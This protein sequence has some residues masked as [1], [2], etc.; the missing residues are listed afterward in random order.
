TGTITF[1]YIL[2]HNQKLLE[3]SDRDYGVAFELLLIIIEKL[4]KLSD[5][6]DIYLMRHLVTH[7][8]F[9][10][11]AFFCYKLVDF[12]YKNKR[13]ATIGF[14]FIVLHPVICT[15]SFFNSKDIP[16]MAMFQICLYIVAVTF[17]KKTVINFIILGISVGLLINIRLMGV[18][19]PFCIGL[20][21]IIDAYKEKKYLHNFKLASI[22]AIATSMTLY[23]SWPYLWTAPIK[24]FVLAFK[25]MANY[26]W[27]GVVLFNGHFI[28]ATEVSWDYIPEWFLLTTPVFFLIIGLL[29]TILLIFHFYKKPSAFIFNSKDRNNLLFLICFFSPL[30]VV[31]LIHSTLYDGWRHMFFIYPSFVLISAYGLNF[32][33]G[34]NKKTM[35]VVYSSISIILMGAYI[36]KAFP[37]EHTYFNPFVTL[38]TP[39][40]IRKNFDLDYWGLSYKQSLEYILKNDDSPSINICV[41]N[42]P[43]ELNVQF[44][45]PRDRTRINIVPMDQATYFITNYR[46]HPQDYE[47]IEKSEFYSIHIEHNTISKIY[48]LK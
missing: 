2:S 35:I 14:L 36:I 41:A 28:K 12:L 32:L 11:G 48:K 7:L 15:N 6:R 18:L 42:F 10:L 8:F 16:F 34:K 38:T 13:M 46:W 33:W 5:F 26:H 22:F 17:R 3:H 20:F 37:L 31:I 39:E 21:L 25:N 45:P 47:D 24:N 1:D 30:I 43:G 29:C 19:L 40:Y 27:G 23:I 44:L 4:L 9:L